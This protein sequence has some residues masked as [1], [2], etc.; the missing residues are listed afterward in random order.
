MP[1]K[2]IAMSSSTACSSRA[3]PNTGFSRDIIIT[4]KIST[5]MYTCDNSHPT[6]DV[7]NMLPYKTQ[8][9]IT[10]VMWPSSKWTL[11]IGHCHPLSFVAVRQSLTRLPVSL[12]SHHPPPPPFCFFLWAILLFQSLGPVWCIYI[13]RAMLPKIQMLAQYQTVVVKI[14]CLAMLNNNLCCCCLFMPYRLID[15]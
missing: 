13:G 9:R 11:Q 7:D 2:V 5:R 4:I 14:T 3:Q 1:E 6:P 15:L 8:C 12:S 10:V